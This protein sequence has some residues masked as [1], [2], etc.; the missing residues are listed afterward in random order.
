MDNGK[1]DLIKHLIMRL[2]MFPTPGEWDG[3]RAAAGI[4]REL[5]M[6]DTRITNVCQKS[7][8][9]ALKF[10]QNFF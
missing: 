2:S 3:G 10:T 6:F 8:G 4:P 5:E 9:R 1:I 7:P